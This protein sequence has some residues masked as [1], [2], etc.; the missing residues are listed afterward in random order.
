MSTLERADYIRTLEHERLDYI[1]QVKQAR[2]AKDYCAETRAALLLKHTNRLLEVNKVALSNA[3]GRK[4]DTGNSMR[5]IKR[6]AH[7]PGRHYN[8]TLRKVTRGL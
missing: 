1:E 8:P 6:P 4:P 7:A 3:Y 2:K 5:Q